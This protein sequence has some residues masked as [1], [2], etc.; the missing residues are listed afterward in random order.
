MPR[1]LRNAVAESRASSVPRTQIARIRPRTTTPFSRSW[2]KRA[3]RTPIAGPGVGSGPTLHRRIRRETSWGWIIST[4]LCPC[5]SLHRDARETGG[6]AD[7][8]AEGTRERGQSRELVG[9]LAAVVA[10]GGTSGIARMDPARHRDGGRLA[11]V[12][13]PA[14]D[15]DLDR[16]QFVNRRRRNLD[17]QVD[18]V[19]VLRGAPG[20]PDL[21]AAPIPR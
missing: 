19:S 14:G 8:S 5:K 18:P 9:I 17:L 10:E 7:R 2:P 3:W 20:R 16:P 15:E 11:R 1:N 21:E 6:K 12:Q 13:E 4:T